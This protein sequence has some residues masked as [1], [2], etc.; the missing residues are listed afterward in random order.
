MTFMGK[1]ADLEDEGQQGFSQPP[2]HLSI[3]W[4]QDGELM[5]WTGKSGMDK[6]QV[7]V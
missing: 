4:A 5:K 7:S 6:C 2:I 3:G 1:G